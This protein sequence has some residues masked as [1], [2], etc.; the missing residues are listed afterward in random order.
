MTLLQILLAEYGTK[1]IVG[2]KHNKTIVQYAK[3]AG[4][5]WV[6]DDETAWCSILMD[7]G[8]MKAGVERTKS[9]AARSWLKVGEVI[10]KPE[11]GDVVI[12]KRGSSNWQGHVGIFINYDGDYINVLGG[13]QSN[14][15][16]ISQYNAKKVLGFRRL[17]KQT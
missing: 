13:N 7:W 4:H 3:E 5:N 14:Q 15:V 16:K 17:K 8:A 10:T 12:F 2:E 11:I 6:N 1:E 9:A